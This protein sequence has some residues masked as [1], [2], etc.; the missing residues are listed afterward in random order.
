MNEEDLKNEQV[1]HHDL[2]AEEI[3]V[4]MIRSE[5]AQW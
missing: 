2:L 5:S 4:M 1:F 3:A